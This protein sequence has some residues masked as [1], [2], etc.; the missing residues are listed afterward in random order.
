MY[1]AKA[2]IGEKAGEFIYAK[3]PSLTHDLCKCWKL[4]CPEC[5]QF[6]YFSQSK[7]PKKR[8]SYFG[9]YDYP[10]KRCPERIPNNNLISQQTSLAASH[11]QDLETAELFVE[12]VCYGIDLEFF[13]SQGLVGLEDN[14]SLIAS[15]IEWFQDNLQH[16]LNDWINHYCK[17]VGFLDWQNP[18][19]EINYLMDWLYVLARRDD[20]LRRL[21][22]YLTAK[23]RTSTTK[24][25]DIQVEFNCS[26]PNPSEEEL[27]W[28]TG[29]RLIIER[30]KNIATTG[31]ENI[32]L[33]ILEKRQYI[34]FK[35]PAYEKQIIRRRKPRWSLSDKNL[36]VLIG[37]SA[38]GKSD[39][40]W[41]K[42]EFPNHFSYQ[43]VGESE[44]LQ[45]FSKEDALILYIDE[46]DDLACKG[47]INKNHHES[48]I[49]G[50]H[51]VLFD[52]SGWLLVVTH[53]EFI[54]QDIAGK[55]AQ[56]ALKPQY[57]DLSPSEAFERFRQITVGR[58][59]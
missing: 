56:L 57:E 18:E 41:F 37:R 55:I 33:S 27:I 11:E 6:L 20:I 30:L 59:P 53:K 17:T 42:S 38:S 16:K 10:D 31:I 32:N 51:K 52:S 12:N 23:Y 39:Y 36:P 24:T 21:V 34:Q 22:Q 35:V 47:F 9:H 26:S 14:S 58:S 1:K 28:L 44:S 8:R 45:D 3:D 29:L 40:I 7:D 2:L 49:R 43:V 15:G 19:R 46:D 54:T 25:E 13:K 48:L 50:I 5:K 4:Y